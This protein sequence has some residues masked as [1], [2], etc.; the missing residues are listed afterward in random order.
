MFL[1]PANKVWG[2][3]MFLQACVSHSVHGGHLYDVTSC[4][5]IWYHVPSGGSQSLVPSEAPEQKL[6]PLDRDLYGEERAIH[7]LLEC[8]L[9]K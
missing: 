4:L 7:I 9:F 2:K 5:A 6:P 3:V 8:I 1:P